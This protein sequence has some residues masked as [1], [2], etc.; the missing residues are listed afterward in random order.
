MYLFFVGPGSQDICSLPL[1]EYTFFF[2][3]VCVS[4]GAFGVFLHESYGLDRVSELS[5]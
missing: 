2:F 4:T 5:S 1:N 3:F